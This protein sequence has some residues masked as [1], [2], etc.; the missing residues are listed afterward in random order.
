M[1][2]PNDKFN[3]FIYGTLLDP[4]IFRAVLGVEMVS[5]PSFADGKTAFNPI[6]AI[7]DGYKKTSPDNTYQY[8]VRDRQHRIRGYMVRDLPPS[9]FESLLHYE[10]KNYLRRTLNVQ[11]AEGTH[12]AVVFVA[13]QKR[14][15]HT[16]GHAFRDPR[17]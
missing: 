6:S 2:A 9:V 14:I 15:D 16:F 13:N 10:G 12:P 11:T 1:P 3:L 4:H 5:D 17:K 7:L 8:A